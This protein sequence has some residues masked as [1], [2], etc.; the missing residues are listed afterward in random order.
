MSDKTLAPA[1]DGPPYCQPPDP[2]PRK[3]SFALPASATDSHFHFYGTAPRYPFAPGR[4]YTPHENPPATARRFFDT[5]G[6]ERAV[7]IQPS[8]YGTDNSCQL[9]GAAALGIPCHVMVVVASTV[10]E[11]ELQKLNDRGARGVRFILTQ[12]NGLSLDHLVTISEKLKG[13]GWHIEIAGK[14]DQLE[15]LTDLLPKVAVEVSLDH[16][17]FLGPKMPASERTRDRVLGLLGDHKCWIKVSAQYRQSKEP[18]PYRDLAVLARAL[19]A[20]APDR[21]VWGSDWPHGLFDGKMMN[22]TDL[23][24]VVADWFPDPA[25]RKRLLVDNPARLYGFA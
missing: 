8:C 14:P 12:P 22:S 11:R 13:T 19:V 5:L 4:S 23:I 24:D 10:S 18:S 17:A 16:F 9:D 2:N 20:R 1:T 7:A 21:V 25:V 6:M 3:P 15:A